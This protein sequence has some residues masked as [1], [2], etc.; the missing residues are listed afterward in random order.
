MNVVEGLY[1][2]IETLRNDF[3][4]GSSAIALNALDIVTAAIDL[5]VDDNDKF[6]SQIAKMI[7]ESKPAMAAVSTICDYALND[8]Q[9]NRPKVTKYFSIEVREKMFRAGEDTVQNAYERLF[10]S[11]DDLYRIATCSFSTNVM[12]LLR[13]ADKRGK[14]IKVYIIKSIWN[15]RDYSTVLAY[16]L[17]QSGILSKIVNLVEFANYRDN[18]DFCII[19]SDG[20]DSSNNLVNGLP[21]KA[22]AELALGHTPFYAIAES[23]KKIDTLKADDGFDFVDFQYVSDILSDN[24]NWNVAKTHKQL[25]NQA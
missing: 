25:V 19:G 1:K 4:N 24:E 7:K 14:R 12:K 22:F 5:N 9:H 11:D 3:L 23:F 17:G 8:Y 18:I 21:S 10:S 15:Q 20:Y 13:L 6:P 16:E 2:R